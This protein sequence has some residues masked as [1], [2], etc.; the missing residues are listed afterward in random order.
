MATTRQSDCWQVGMALMVLATWTLALGMARPVEAQ[1]AGRALP[2]TPFRAVI[3]ADGVIARSGAGDTFYEVGR[4]NRDSQP[5][6]VHGVLRGWFQIEPFEGVYS[7]VARDDV[8]LNADRTVAI[9]NRDQTVVYAKASDPERDSFTQQRVL[10]SGARLNVHRVEGDVV[11]V[12]PPSDVRVFIRAENARALAPGEVVPP[13]DRPTTPTVPIEPRDPRAPDR[14][15]TPPVRGPAPDQSVT[16]QRGGFFEFGGSVFPVAVSSVLFERLAAGGTDRSITLR[17]HRDVPSSD[18]AAFMDRARRQGFTRI[19]TETI[20][21]DSPQPP[22]TARPDRTPRNDEATTEAQPEERPDRTQTPER[23]RRDGFSGIAPEVRAAEERFQEVVEKPLAERNLGELIT[24]FEA[25]SEDSE[26]T[27]PDR[28]LVE[29]RVADL[30]RMRAAQ[31]ALAMV[32]SAQRR[33]G[34]RAAEA[35]RFQPADVPP[36]YDLT[37]IL[38]PSIVFDGRARPQLLRLRD[39]ATNNTLVYIRPEAVQGLD[40]LISRNVGII[41]RIGPV[42]PE[43][44]VRIFELQRIDR[45]EEAPAP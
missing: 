24:V 22:V 14:G 2:D 17:V 15:V 25:L 23:P 36:V 29:V 5:V 34:E 31:Q 7:V 41:G 27:Q 16:L 18:V 39:P 10:F 38:E 13:R 32:D 35:P 19:R 21:E 30:R 4:L 43:K 45:L 6:T 37:G 3:T 11:V 42:H 44:G 40:R 28:R 9:V 1:I 8:R 26:L 12:T 20:S 33:S